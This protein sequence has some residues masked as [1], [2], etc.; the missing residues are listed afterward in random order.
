MIKRALITKTSLGDSAGTHII[1]SFLAGTLSLA[2]CA[3]IDVLKSRIQN[4]VGGTVVRPSV[5]R[6]SSSSDPQ[7]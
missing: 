3:P 2:L 1:S 5:F 6:K 4:T 7:D